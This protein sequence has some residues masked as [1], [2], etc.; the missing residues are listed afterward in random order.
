MQEQESEIVDTQ[1]SLNS[2]NKQIGGIHSKVVIVRFKMNGC[3]H[4][5][6]SQPIW[7]NTTNHLKKVYSL[8]PNT[9]IAQIDSKLA[10]EFINHHHLVTKDNQPYVTNG[11]PEHVV[12]INGKAISQGT[13]VP[14]IPHLLKEKY[15][16]KKNPKKTKK[17]KK[18]KKKS[19]KN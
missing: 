13:T 9:I 5:V 8:S 14:T 4:C 3:V 18:K 16:K 11:F 19:K 12:I 15:V 1:Q 2:L 7:D 10:E 17:N 6:N